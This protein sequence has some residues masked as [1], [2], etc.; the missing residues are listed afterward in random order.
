MTN[1]V[2]LAHVRRQR[3]PGRTYRIEATHAWRR[4]DGTLVVGHDPSRVKISAGIVIVAAIVLGM[5]W[6]A[7]FRGLGALIMLGLLVVLFAML[8]VPPS[9]LEIDREMGALRLT[10]W[11]LV[12]LDRI[13]A[14]LEDVAAVT[15]AEVH[16]PGGAAEADTA[17]EIQ[18]RLEGGETIALQDPRNAKGHVDTTRLAAIVAAIRAELAPPSAGGSGSQDGGTADG[19]QPTGGLH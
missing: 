3:T 7:Q 2:D 6:G 10:A 12:R 14:P 19:S 11:R 18:I 15:L 4:A 13:Q 17:A 8:V 1:I 9:R 16:N 5:W